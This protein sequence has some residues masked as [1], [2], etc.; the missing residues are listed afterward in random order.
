MTVLVFVLPR[1]SVAVTVI[2]L[3]PEVRTPEVTSAPVAENAP[4]T[5]YEAI[6]APLPGEAEL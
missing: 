6:E 3:D 2:D 5:V 4:E 1:V